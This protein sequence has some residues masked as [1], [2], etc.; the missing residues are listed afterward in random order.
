[1]SGHNNA[2]KIPSV[3]QYLA[4]LNAIPS[5]HDVATQEENFDIDEQLAQFTNVEFLDFDTGGDFLDHQITDFNSDHGARSRRQSAGNT[6]AD[7]KGMDFVNGT[8]LY[9]VD[10]NSDCRCFGQLW[11]HVVEAIANLGIDDSLLKIAH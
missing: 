10:I 7:A 4:N 3:S 8:S 5:A 9:N 1:M 2:R 11:Q 6:T